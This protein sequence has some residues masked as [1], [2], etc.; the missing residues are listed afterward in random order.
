MKIQKKL[1]ITNI[2]LSI[3]P[4]LL[5]VTIFLRSYLT[6]MLNDSE[7]YITDLSISILKRMDDMISEVD[8]MLN[9]VYSVSDFEEHIIE[10]AKIS[11]E[12][13]DYAYQ[14]MRADSLLK[15]DLSYLLFDKS[16]IEDIIIIDQAGNNYYI[17]NNV[18]HYE[19]DF[20]KE[21]FYK[22]TIDK[23][24]KCNIFAADS[25]VFY[26]EYN[27]N[28]FSIAKILKSREDMKQ[29]GTVIV[30][31]KVDALRESFAN[32][33][34]DDKQRFMIRNDQEVILDSFELPLDVKTIDQLLNDSHDNKVNYQDKNYLIYSNTSDKT[35]LQLIWLSPYSML[36]SKTYPIIYYI[37]FIAIIIL[38][39]CIVCSILTAATIS[40]PIKKLDLMTKEILSNHVTETKIAHDNSEIGQLYENFIIMKNQ[41]NN[42]LSIEKKSRI[43]FLA[44][45]INPHFLYNTLD[46]AYMSAIANDD[47]DT[48]DIIGRINILL[49]MVVREKSFIT[50]QKEL[51]IVNAYVDIQKMRYPHKFSF[52]VIVQESLYDLMI[53][54]MI[55]QPIV[56]N[57]ITHGILELDERGY[58]QIDIK[59]NNNN[60]QITVTNGPGKM[61]EEQLKVMNDAI[62]NQNVYEVK[63]IG[64]K[65]IYERLNLYYQNNIELYICNSCT[66]DGVQ[67]NI[68]I[69]L[70]HGITI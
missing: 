45:Q 7:A 5:I 64:L 1:I 40:K 54:K 60:L 55:L 46:S 3:I 20:R 6:T 13:E 23:N 65:N 21:E 31:I 2:L 63:H 41:I 10:A 24:G 39:L 37:V 29:I 68:H 19:K 49:K 9:L 47:M 38:I 57:A 25:A 18:F 56:E 8:R 15:N 14:L 16:Y 67:V 32:Y 51:E 34:E 52:K 11:R 50:L 43:E 17:G 48:S 62:I 66:M 58:I 53:P 26:K 4:L 22:N 36:I 30:T 28:Y 70:S 33:L 42:L 35:E 59:E 12:D 44:S 27:M 69:D 61:T